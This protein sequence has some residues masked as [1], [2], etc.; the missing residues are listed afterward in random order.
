M[1]HLTYNSADDRWFGR[2][3][4]RNLTDKHYIESAQNVDPLWVWAFYGEPRFV[5]VAARLQVRKQR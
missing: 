4:V 1:P 5:G 3:F 2:V